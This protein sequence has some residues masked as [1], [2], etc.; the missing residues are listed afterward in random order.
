M[1]RGQRAP[2][3]FG[4]CPHVPKVP[5]FHPPLPP[6]IGGI[7]RLKPA[8]S[9]AEACRAPR[10]LATV[11][12]DPSIPKILSLDSYHRTGWYSIVVLLNYV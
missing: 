3:S 8:A 11:Q 6:G 9:S 5:N 4:P 2:S 7:L 1:V 12:P 10:H